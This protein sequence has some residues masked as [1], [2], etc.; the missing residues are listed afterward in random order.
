MKCPVCS[1]DLPATAKFCGSCGTTI[2]S[3]PPQDFSAPPPSMSGPPYGNPSG[4]SYGGFPPPNYG[5]NQ[6]SGGDKKYKALRTIAN[7]YKILAFVLGGLMVIG[8]LIVM[9]SGA[10]GTSS[11]GGP[12]MMAG[13]FIG[14]LIMIIYAGLVFVGFYGLGEF[15][16][17]FLDIEENT[18]KT[19]DLLSK[20]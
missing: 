14:G 13:G 20:K 17:L 18:R 9:A 3:P 16:Y 1:A 10:V 7:L 12:S 2:S 11:L 4:P 6:S 19:N 15:I 8:A 5:V